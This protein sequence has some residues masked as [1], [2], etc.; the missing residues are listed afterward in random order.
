MFKMHDDLAKTGSGQTHLVL[1]YPPRQRVHLR[2]VGLPGHFSDAFQTLHQ[3]NAK[4]FAPGLISQDFL[5]E[6]AG[7]GWL[8]FEH[9]HASVFLPAACLPASLLFLLLVLLLFCFCARA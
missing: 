7:A 8:A 9:Q 2:V 1:S 4:H 3:N 5:S 6:A